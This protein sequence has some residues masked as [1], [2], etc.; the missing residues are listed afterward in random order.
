MGILTGYT[1]AV[2]L[3]HLFAGSPQLRIIWPKIE[4]KINI[5]LYGNRHKTVMVRD[6]RTITAE[7]QVV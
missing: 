7:F 1:G 6:L 4:R 5:L 2:L 3:R